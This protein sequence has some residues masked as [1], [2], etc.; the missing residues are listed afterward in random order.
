M[1]T[2]RNNRKLAAVS[3]ET[4]ENTRNSQLKNKLNSKMTEEYITQVSEES[5]RIVT[6]KLSGI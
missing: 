2:L 3:K 1:A 4:P 5:E 6:K